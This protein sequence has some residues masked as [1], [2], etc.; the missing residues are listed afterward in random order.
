VPDSVEPGEPQ[1]VSSD[2]SAVAEDFYVMNQIRTEADVASYSAAV[3]QTN[4]D[5]Q[6][7]DSACATS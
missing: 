6:S 2:I 4:S 7:L 3:Q 5:I 1:D